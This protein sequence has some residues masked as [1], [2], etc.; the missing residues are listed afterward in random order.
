ME[1][2]TDELKKLLYASIGAASVVAEKTSKTIEELAK[3][4]ETVVED[5]K[6]KNEE[7]KTKIQKQTEDVK[8]K[9]KEA[10]TAKPTAEDILNAVESMSQEELA[11]LKAKLDQVTSKE[12][13]TSC[14]EEK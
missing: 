7:I 3:K 9:V 5:S 8:Q 11:L 10:V 1:P 14:E 2:L 13:G 6:V 4:G 12:E